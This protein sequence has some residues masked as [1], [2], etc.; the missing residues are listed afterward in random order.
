M[1]LRIGKVMKVKR[2]W[3]FIWEDDSLISWVVNVILA[4]LIVKFLIFPGLGLV[5][6]TSHPV[7]AVVSESMDHRGNF[8]DWWERQGSWYEERGIMKEE[9]MQYDMK[10][11]F[12]KGDII[13]LRGKDK[14]EI[15][16]VVVFSANSNNPII[17]RVV[18]KK[19]GKYQTKG[20]ANSDSS[21]T[22]G[23]V[24][25]SKERVIGK[26]LFRVPFLGWVKVWASE[27]VGG[28]ENVVLS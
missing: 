14:F 23:E 5:L 17:H 8:D 25:I 21:K 24:D 4:F 7:V 26:A 19:D 12:K 15:G 22:L 10:N 3:N 2:V 27:I 9:F 16:E 6:D 28:V 11:G 1:D 13:F 20:D 18:E